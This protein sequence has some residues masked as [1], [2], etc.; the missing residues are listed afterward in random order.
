MS[1]PDNGARGVSDHSARPGGDE[2][3]KKTFARSFLLRLSATAGLTRTEAYRKKLESVDLRQAD[4][5]IGKKAY[6]SRV[7]PTEL[8]SFV[9]DLDEIG[10]RLAALRD[11]KEEKA[12]ASF[13]EKAQAAASGAARTAKVKA[14][15]LK[16]SGLF[17]DLGAKLRKRPAPDPALNAEIAGANAVQ[18]RIT[19]LDTEIA[20]L[21]R[22]SWTKHPLPF[23][24]AAI[25]VAILAAGIISLGH[26]RRAPDVTHTRQQ[27]QP[28]ASDAMAAQLAAIKQQSEQTMAA[29]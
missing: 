19:S 7:V 29:L 15:E 27:Q 6:E 22:D 20:S 24:I 11:G 21:R 17:K 5:R 3:S 28:V 23:L 8:S 9:T 1:E 26:R 14:L 16:Q 12:A 4:Y 18:E 13:G 2:E 25:I 10:A